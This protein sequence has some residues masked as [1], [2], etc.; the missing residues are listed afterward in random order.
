VALRSLS[1]ENA[2]SPRGGRL[3]RHLIVERCG[4]VRL[5]GE[6]ET[7]ASLQRQRL[8]FVSIS[9]RARARHSFVCTKNTVFTSATLSGA[10]VSQITALRSG[11]APTTSRP[12]GSRAVAGSFFDLA[13]DRVPARSFRRSPCTTS[14]VLGSRRARSPSSWDC[15]PR[16]AQLFGWASG[17][18]WERPGGDPGPFDRC[19]LLTDVVFKDD[20]LTSRRTSHRYVPTRCE[21]SRFHAAMPTSAN[22]PARAQG[23]VFPKR[24][25][26]GVPLM[27]RR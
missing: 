4:P 20:R 27:P 6:G 23:V 25:A 8:T 17:R 22:R 11:F 2:R 24:R 16:G 13:V 5:S 10:L 14:L 26:A 15:L 7:H 1:L 21:S 12:F 18:A 9:R 3:G 19:L